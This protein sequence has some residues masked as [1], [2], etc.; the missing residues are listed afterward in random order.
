MDAIHAKFEEWM[1]AAGGDLT[2]EGSKY[3]D[4]KI[5]LAFM[6]FIEGRYAGIEEAAEKMHSTYN[7]YSTVIRNLK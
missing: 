1:L 3:L 2:R 7:N 5:D 6:A 4:P